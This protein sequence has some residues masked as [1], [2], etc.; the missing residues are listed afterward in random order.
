LTP[1][2]LEIFRLKVQ[3]EALRVLVRGLF[4]GIANS[5]PTGPDTMRQRFAELRNE[6]GKIVLKGAPPEYSDMLTAEY[7]EALDNLLSFIE[8]GLHS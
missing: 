1:E 4:T 2:Q 3:L 7:Q 5:S 6:H 8:G